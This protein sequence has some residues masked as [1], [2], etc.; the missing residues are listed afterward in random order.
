LVSTARYSAHFQ[1]LQQLVRYIYN[2]SSPHPQS[3]N[4]KTKHSIYR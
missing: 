1:E 4:T 2:Y 3:K